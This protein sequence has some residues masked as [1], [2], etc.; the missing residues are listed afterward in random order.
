MKLKDFIEDL[1]N[2]FF[3]DIYC[4]LRSFFFRWPKKAYERIRY[5]IAYE[6]SWNMDGY[7]AEI[8]ERGLKQFSDHNCAYPGTDEYPD[9]QKWQQDL[10]RASKAFGYYARRWEDGGMDDED[11][12]VY[13]AMPEEERKTIKEFPSGEKR[14]EYDWAIAWLGKSHGSLWW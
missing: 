11:H 13:E 5:G 3:Y 6:D 2:D 10:L 7:L 1:V 14:K 12:A 8:L 9:F 4:W